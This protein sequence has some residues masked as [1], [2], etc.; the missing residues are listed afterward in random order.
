MLFPLYKSQQY[1]PSNIRNTQIPYLTYE[2][3]YNQLFPYLSSLILSLRSY[4]TTFDCCSVAEL[5]A[6]E[7]MKALAQQITDFL[8]G[9]I[10]LF[11]EEGKAYIYIYT[12]YY[13]MKV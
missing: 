5:K 9:S 3:L 7:E 11:K 8:L 1:V 4:E 2:A 10:C 12:Q 6:V 13:L